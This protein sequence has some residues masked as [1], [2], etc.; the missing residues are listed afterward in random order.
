MSCSSF[1]HSI[2]RFYEKN[3]AS[4]K[5]T[6]VI[7]KGDFSLKKFTFLKKARRK[8]KRERKYLKPPLVRSIKYPRN[9]F[10]KKKENAKRGVKD[11]PLI[12][13]KLSVFCNY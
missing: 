10:T 13:K 7:C 9:G 6:F 11:N 1:F 3:R 5:L 4:L 2:H 8:R 12:T